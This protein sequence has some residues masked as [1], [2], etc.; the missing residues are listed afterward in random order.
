MYQSVTG[1]G[2]ITDVGT[3]TR[4]VANLGSSGNILDAIRE[5][6]MSPDGVKIVALTILYIARNSGVKIVA[7]KNVAQWRQG[8][9]PQKV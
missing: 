5:S 4:F 9:I 3:E 2:L 8:L 6:R 7:D 1:I